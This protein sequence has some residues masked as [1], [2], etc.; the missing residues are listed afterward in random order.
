MARR[1][2]SVHLRVSIGAQSA[3]YPKH[4]AR[5]MGI[6]P[7]HETLIGMVANMEPEPAKKW[8]AKLEKLGARGD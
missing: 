3:P 4:L 2:H 5:M 8:L 7:V 1:V 6:A